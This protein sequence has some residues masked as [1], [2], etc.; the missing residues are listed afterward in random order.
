MIINS[1][2]LYIYKIDLLSEKPNMCICLEKYTLY[3]FTLSYLNL[4]HTHTYYSY[5]LNKVILRINMC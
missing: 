2:I 1:I 4:S 5:I 3:I